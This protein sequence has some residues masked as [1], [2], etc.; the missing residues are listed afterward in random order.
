M[1]Q[2]IFMNC[3][4]KKIPDNYFEKGS[5]FQAY[6]YKQVSKRNNYGR[7]QSTSES[8]TVPTSQRR[9]AQIY[10]FPKYCELFNGKKNF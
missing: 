6:K 3:I 4:E 8:R 9:V 2:I 5:Y 7:P 1:F 10:I